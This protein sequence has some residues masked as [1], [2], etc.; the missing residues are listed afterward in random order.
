[1]FMKLCRV[2]NWNL[3]LERS[4]I[5]CSAMTVGHPGTDDMTT[6]P[7]LYRHLMALERR[8]ILQLQY[9]INFVKYVHAVAEARRCS[10]RHTF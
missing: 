1:M 9:N 5:W 3:E 8:R 4:F 2:R 6:F 10:A 7:L